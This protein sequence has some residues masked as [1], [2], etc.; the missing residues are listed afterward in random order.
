[1]RITSFCLA[2]L[3]KDSFLRMAD[4]LRID[5]DGSLLGVADMLVLLIFGVCDWSFEGVLVL[6]GVLIFG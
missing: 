4:L 3:K 5:L 6:A 1:V 2:F